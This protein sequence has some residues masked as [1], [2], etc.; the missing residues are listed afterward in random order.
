[1]ASFNLTISPAQLELV[2]KPGASI[3]QAYEITNNSEYQQ[4]LTTEIL[5]WKPT[6]SDGSVTYDNV[7]PQ[8]GINFS[9]NNADLKLGQTFLLKPQEKKQLVLKI[10]LDPDAP[11]KDFY[12]TFFLTQDIS[13]SINYDSTST[14]NQA[15]IGTHILLTSSDTAEISVVSKVINFATTPRLKDILF[16]PI[17][18]SAKIENK[19][20]NFFKVNGLLTIEKNG[21]KIKELNLT[22]DN[23]LSH[24]TRTL[25]CNY[26]KPEAPEPGACIFRPPLWPGHYTA[27]ITL[28]S[29]LSTK[30]ESISFFVFPFSPLILITLITILFFIISKLKPRLPQ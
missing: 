1:M 21:L 13:N 28:D 22:S 20:D 6:D 27:T 8:S 18:L 25:R 5:P 11:K 10:K 29:S 26:G 24:H 15:K 3:T 17:T 14:Q 7:Y 30:T 4:Y 2:A 9:L 19:S 23:V 16:T 12:Y